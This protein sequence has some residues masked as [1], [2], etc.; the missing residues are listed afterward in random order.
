MSKKHHKK[1]QDINQ[2]VQV[3][4]DKWPHGKLSLLTAH[5]IFALDETRDIYGWTEVENMDEAEKMFLELMRDLKKLNP[6]KRDKPNIK[7][8][9][10]ELLQ[11]EENEDEVF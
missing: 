7:L 3:F 4:R 9:E 11:T 10:K 2:Q 8:L 1:A 6:E 5:L